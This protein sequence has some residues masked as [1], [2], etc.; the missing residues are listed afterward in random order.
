[1]GKSHDLATGVS[2]QDQTETDARYHTKT[3]SDAAFVAKAG[4]TM[5][6]DLNI[7]SGAIT[8]VALTG[9]T[10]SDMFLIYNK[11]NLIYNWSNTWSI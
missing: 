8:S 2:Y 10:R 5:T 11:L 6:G 1:M 7:Q 3:A 4:D 9:S